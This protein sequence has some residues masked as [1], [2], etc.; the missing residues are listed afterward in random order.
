[1][2]PMEGGT[3]KCKSE[4]FLLMKPM[5]AEQVNARVRGSVLMTTD[6]GGTGQCKCE[7]FLLMKPMRAEQVK[8]KSERFLLMKPMRAGQVNAGGIVW[9]QLS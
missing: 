4:R 3:G 1:M 9:S 7:R 6:E 8:C 2:K 5:R